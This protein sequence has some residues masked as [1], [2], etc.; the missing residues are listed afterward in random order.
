MPN[1]CSEKSA[2]LP[3][4]DRTILLEMQPLQDLIDCLP[5]G[6]Y[7]CDSEG[8]IT[9]F[10][11]HAEQLWGRTPKLND[12]VD[13]YCGSFKLYL[14]NGQP[15]QHD[16]CWMARALKTGR[17]FNSEEI[18]VE[19]PDG[20]RLTILAHANPIHDAQGQLV[21]ALNVLV[22]ISDRKRAEEDQALLAA[23]IESSDDAIV[24]KAL[25]GSILSWNRGAERLYGWTAEEV[26]GKS[27]MLI[28]P[29]D[30]RDEELEILSR[31]RRGERI[32]HFETVRLTRDGHRRNIS[33]TVSPVRDRAG[34]IF[35]ASKV[36]RDITAR[37]Q[38]EASLV[39]LKDELAAQLSDL[40]QLQDMSVRLSTT[41]DLEP[42]L[43]QT[44][45]TAATIENTSMGLL[46][47]RDQYQNE[48]RVGA[49][50][51][52]TERFLNKLQNL[53]A[54]GGFCGICFKERRRVIIEDTETDLQFET[55]KQ[56]A[57]DEGFGA[58][59]CTP[60]ITRS[61]TILGV[62]T[63]LFRRPHRPSNR[64]MQLID[65]CGRQAVDFIENARLYA[66][67]CEADRRKDEFLATLAHELRNP[68][69]PLSNSLHLLKLTDDLSPEVQRIRDL[70]ERQVNHMVRL[71]DDLM[72]VS[73]ITRGKIELRVRAGR[74]GRGFG[75]CH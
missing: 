22:D 3:D 59:H 55:L 13:R 35:A 54:D 53:L 33:L 41:L 73:R 29:P 9:C 18:I 52:L 74:I 20:S 37:K 47:V 63:T 5:A 27:I 66:Q 40:R 64:E 44:L 58:M 30:R 65:L 51:G 21:G 23:I 6:T 70:M 14:A 31:L 36:A 25:D 1:N 2:A 49:S 4:E 12:P 46:A 61:G 16:E 71:V 67:L 56:L 69:A 42:I 15:I 17:S 62:L 48:L 50:L 32:D 19:R 60:L 26:A 57:R 8:L 11:R 39:A 28:I 72:E 24:S 45:R 10:N 68:L 34:R 38:A 43:E 7:T 75:Q